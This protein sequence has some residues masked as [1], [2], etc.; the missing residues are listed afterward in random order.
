MN[1]IVVERASLDAT[2]GLTDKKS[3][4]WVVLANGLEVLLEGPTR[5][6]VGVS[7]GDARARRRLETDR[8]TDLSSRPHWV[9]LVLSARSSWSLG[10]CHHLVVV[11]TSRLGPIPRAKGSLPG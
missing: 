5:E 3:Y 10:R 8:P 9:A 11:A 2:K 4:R 7:E 6:E 1:P